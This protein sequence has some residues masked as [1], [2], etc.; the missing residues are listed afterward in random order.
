[1][2]VLAPVS[3]IMTKK[4]ITVGPD[5]KLITVKKIFEEHNIH[6]IPVVNYTTIVGMISDTDLKFF[7]RG[8]AQNR[9]D[10]LI[11][12]VRLEA[13]KVNEIMTKKLAKIESSDP[14]RTALELFKLNRFHALPVVDGEELVGI[15]TTYDIIK[16]LAE[17]PS[18]LEDYGDPE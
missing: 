1:M 11:D 15:V 10:Q 18:S 4:L 17:A 9:S 12:E 16:A 5:D 14:I 2:N 3:T 7:L 8:S 13:F 6:H